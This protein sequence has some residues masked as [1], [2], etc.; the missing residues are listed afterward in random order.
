LRFVLLAALALAA[1]GCGL[2]GPLALPE[3]ST[4]VVIRGPQ[5]PAGTPAPATGPAAPATTPAKPAV[6]PDDR[7]PPP[8]LPGG[9][10]G[11]SSGG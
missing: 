9:S 10:P 6:P 3:K 5:A 2:K 8:P 7:M 1:T 11:S 4:H